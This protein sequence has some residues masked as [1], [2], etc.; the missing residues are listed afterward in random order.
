MISLGFEAGVVL[1]MFNIRPLLHF[2]LQGR[3]LAKKHPER[4]MSQG[5]ALT[6]IILT[7]LFFPCCF[8]LV[9]P[10]RL[11]IGASSPEDLSALV[12][13]TSIALSALIFPLNIPALIIYYLL[14][15]TSLGSRAVGREAPTSM[16]R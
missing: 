6:A 12:L 15:Y 9:L 16:S 1:L 8:A 13:D 14:A 4:P 10:V 5:R 7:T 11:G 3:K 2:L